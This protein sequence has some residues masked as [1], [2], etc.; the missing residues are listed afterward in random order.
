MGF[1]ARKEQGSGVQH[2]AEA[3]I[4]QSM[5]DLCERRHRQECRKFFRGEG[6]AVWAD[7]ARLSSLD[8]IRILFML[9]GKIHN[10]EYDTEYPVS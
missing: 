2:L 10:H 3:V 5:A 4:L 8:Q 1:L 7:L 6:F 9:R